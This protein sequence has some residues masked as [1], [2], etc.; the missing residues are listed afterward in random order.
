MFTGIIEST[1]KIVEF[2]QGDQTLQVYLE[3]PSFFND[4]K[5]GDSVAVNGVCLTVETITDKTL[6]F[7]IALETLKV[8]SWNEEKLSEMLLNLERPLKVGDRLHGHWVTGHVDSLLTVK[9]ESW[10]GENKIMHLELLDDYK[11]YVV[12]KG[13]V[14]LNGV[15]LTIN[16]VEADHFTVCLIPETLK[17][18]N[19]KQNFKGQKINV[20][21]DYLAKIVKQSMATKNEN[22][23]APAAGGKIG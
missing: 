12:P 5:V 14:T 6:K 10:V 20:E 16:D 7:T 3:K 22:P 11:S 15:A 1:A 4:L 17:E 8:T 2:E 9:D 13:S 23:Y 18:T 19:L 21:F